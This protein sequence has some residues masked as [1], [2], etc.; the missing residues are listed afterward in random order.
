[1]TDLFTTTL[2]M[3]RGARNPTPANPHSPDPTVPTRHALSTCVPWRRRLLEAL[4]LSID[5]TL[6]TLAAALRARRL[7]DTSLLVF[8]SDNGGALKCRREDG[9]IVSL[10]LC[11][12]HAAARL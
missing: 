1:M 4:A 8:T 9:T 6:G 2:R 11:L 7:L 3:R 12:R 10:R 5:D